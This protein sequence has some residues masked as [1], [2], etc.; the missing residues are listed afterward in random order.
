MR[1]ERQLI[2]TM[3]VVLKLLLRFIKCSMVILEYCAH[4]IRCRNYWTVLTSHSGGV[5]AFLMAWRIHSRCRFSKFSLKLHL[6]WRLFGSLL[7]PKGCQ[8]VLG[9]KRLLICSS[10]QRSA[11]DFLQIRSYPQH[12][13]SSANSFLCRASR[14]LLPPDRCGLPC[15]PKKRADLFE[16]SARLIQLLSLLRCTAGVSAPFLDSRTRRWPATP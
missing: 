5:R 1:A 4:W 14:W 11:F 13:C 3:R 16:R 9:S 12:P 15:A 8:K 10:G 7:S 6:I 2:W